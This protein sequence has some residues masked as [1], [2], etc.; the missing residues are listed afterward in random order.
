V[1]ARTDVRLDP[2]AVERVFREAYG[3]AV[4]TLI[5]TFGDITL[6]EDAVQDSFVVASDR[7]RRD[8]IPPNPAGWIVT[9]ARNR[10]IGD[11]R[12]SARGPGH[13]AVQ[14]R[15]VLP[16]ERLA[17]GGRGHVLGQAVQRGGERVA[18]RL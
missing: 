17:E 9:T 10:A 6:A 15:R 3:Q 7:W 5:R 12:R 13:V 14:Q 11:L 16:F 4:A 18:I 1:S 8:G 2:I